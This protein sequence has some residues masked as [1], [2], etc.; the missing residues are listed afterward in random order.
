M[1]ETPIPTRADMF[2]EISVELHE[3]LER[4]EKILWKN[5][6]DPKLIDDLFDEEFN[7]KLWNI[8]SETLYES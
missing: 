8:L 7:Q 3:Y 6:L 5:R 2:V 1:A 4:I